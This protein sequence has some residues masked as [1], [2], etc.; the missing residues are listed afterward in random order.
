MLKRIHELLNER[1]DF[2]FETTLS[3]RSY[4]S[5]IKEAH[6]CN[7]KVTLL[8]FWLSSPQIA[9]QRVA[10]RVSEGGHNIPIDIIERRYF[11]GIKNLLKLYVSICEKW[12][13]INNVGVNS[14]IIAEGGA[15]MEKVIINRDIW[16]I[17]L[18]QY[19]G[20]ST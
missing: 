8:F 11:R 20:S 3:T 5:L 4:V 1:A 9:F 10:K 14:T 16:E 18:T 12:F 7:Y 19:D 6:Q 2:A 17:I 13:I 15:K